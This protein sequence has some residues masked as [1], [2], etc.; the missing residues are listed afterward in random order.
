MRRLASRWRRVRP[1]SQNQPLHVPIPGR[2]TPPLHRT[3]DSTDTQTTPI[4]SRPRIE[5]PN[6]A[7][8]A[9]WIIPNIEHFRFDKPFMGAPGPM[10]DVPAFAQRDYGPRVG[11][12]R[13]MELFDKYGLRATVALNADVCRFNPQI[14]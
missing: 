2:T 5:W 9:F 13:F 14:I 10:P 7:R 4:P 6:G 8:V 11:I 3:H 12:W 1:V